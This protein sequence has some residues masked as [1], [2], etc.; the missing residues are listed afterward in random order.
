MIKINKQVCIS[1]QGKRAN[2]EDTALFS[3]G[4]VFVVCDGVGGNEKGEVASHIVAEAFLECG[5]ESQVP[6][7]NQVLKLAETHLDEHLAENP[8]TAGMATTLTFSMPTPQGMLVAWCGDS[9]VYQF[10]EGRIIFQT[11]DHSWVN[12]AVD[13]GIITPEEAVNHPKSNVITRA[14]QGS[15][16][17]TQLDITLLKDVKKNDFF[18]HCSDGVLEAWT[19]TDLEAL[20]NS[21][22]DVNELA[23]VLKQQ[24]EI[25]SRDNFT[26]IIYAIESSDI[27]PE[28]MIPVQP[29][30]EQ[31]YEAAIIIDK[32]PDPDDNTLA[33]STSITEKTHQNTDFVKSPPIQNAKTSEPSK[34]GGKWKGYGVA[35]IIPILLYGI[36]SLFMTGKHE[37]LT[38]NKKQEQPKDEDGATEK[39]KEK[40]AAKFA[41]EQKKNEASEDSNM[42]DKVNALVKG[43][44]VEPKPAEGEKES[45]PDK[46]DDKSKLKKVVKPGKPNGNSN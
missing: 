8:E 4:K 21:N 20:F 5:I 1:E 26:A 39:D 6:D 11:R 33:F 3:E 7:L 29:I 35:I 9:R 34:G 13:N 40:D 14:I 37:N 2:N 31:V 32:V 38:G 45:K 10:R 15:H 23:S 44:K 12:E 36:Y 17:P 22:G 25:D 16:K 41:D 19:D 42:N 18:L 24:C 30:N 27:Q 43:T 28:L 46:Q